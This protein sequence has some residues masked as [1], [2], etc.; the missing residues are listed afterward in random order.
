MNLRYG[1]PKGETTVASLAGSGSLSLESGVLSALT[2]DSR[3]SI[4]ANR[5]VEAPHERRA[6]RTRLPS[7]WARNYD[8]TLIDVADR[9]LKVA[10]EASKATSAA[11]SKAHS[12]LCDTF[13][14]PDCGAL[15][16]LL[17]SAMAWSLS[18][19][20]LIIAAPCC[21]HRLLT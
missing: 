21:V 3:F 20:I 5:A 19:P 9:A 12:A 11:A 10:E 8:D 6:P 13:P 1:V 7:K 16:L 18:L 17:R 4:A 14:F 15:L 2:G